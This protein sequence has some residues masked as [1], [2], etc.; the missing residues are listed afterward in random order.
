MHSPRAQH[1][2]ST[3]TL[4]ASKDGPCGKDNIPFPLLLSSWVEFPGLPRMQMGPVTEPWHGKWGEVMN[5]S[6]RTGLKLLPRVPPMALCLHPLASLCRRSKGELWQDGRTKVWKSTDF[7][8]LITAASHD[9]QYS[10][11]KP[12]LMA[13]EPELIGPRLSSSLLL[14]RFLFLFCSLHWPLELR[15]CQ[16]RSW[17]QPPLVLWR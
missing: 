8:F 12:S 2:S 6:S 9:D 17:E 14:G 7:F 15:T 11:Y 10:P 16:V 5:A 13:P 1:C 4:L 3:T